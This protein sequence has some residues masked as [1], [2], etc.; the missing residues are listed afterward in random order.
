MSYLNMWSPLLLANTYY[1]QN[2]FTKFRIYHFSISFPF[3]SQNIN[4]P[5]SFLFCSV[6]HEMGPLYVASHLISYYASPTPFD[7]HHKTTD[8]AA[9]HSCIIILDSTA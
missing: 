2:H 1:L 5:S 8:P 6:D 3:E 7:L 9:R 4:L